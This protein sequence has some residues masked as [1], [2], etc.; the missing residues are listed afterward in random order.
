MGKREAEYDLRGF[1]A[2]D[3]L[4][5]HQDRHEHGDKSHIRHTFQPLDPEKPEIVIFYGSPASGKVRPGDDGDGDGD[6]IGSGRE[7]D[8]QTGRRENGIAGMVMVMAKRLR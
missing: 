7:D 5:E 4:M 1:N 8:G 3:A 2:F 6:G